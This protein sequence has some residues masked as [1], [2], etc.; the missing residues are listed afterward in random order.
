MTNW[1]KERDLVHKDDGGN[2]FFNGNIHDIKF[3]K[4]II[5]K[6]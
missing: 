3:I 6:S 4:K 5:I 1:L 2:I